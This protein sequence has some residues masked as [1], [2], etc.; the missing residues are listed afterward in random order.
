[1]IFS[2]IV[3]ILSLKCFLLCYLFPLINKE[4]AIVR[5][6][7]LT[8]FGG[9]RFAVSAVDDRMTHPEVLSTFDLTLGVET[10]LNRHHIGIIK[11]NKYTIQLELDF[12]INCY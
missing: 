3:Y 5:P 1:M 8:P 11:Y 7:S 2:R 6:P 9:A 10:L 12:Y 4:Q